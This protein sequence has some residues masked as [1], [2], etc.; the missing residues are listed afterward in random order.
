MQAWYHTG[1][2]FTSYKI[3]AL[4]DSYK[5]NKG[6]LSETTAN[7]YPQFAGGFFCL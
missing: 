4:A 5:A 3:S 2:Y 6:M 7:T 1:H